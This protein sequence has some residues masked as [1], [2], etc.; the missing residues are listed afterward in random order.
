M[1]CQALGSLHREETLSKMQ[2]FMQLFMR[3]CNVCTAR[4]YTAILAFL[5]ARR[6]MHIASYVYL[7]EATTAPTARFPKF[8]H[9]TML[10]PVE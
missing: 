7:A 1:H 6:V 4:D 10:I 8:S 9:D 2:L 5:R 3:S